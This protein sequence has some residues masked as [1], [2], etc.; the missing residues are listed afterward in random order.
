MSN[1]IQSVVQRYIETWN[2]TNATRRRALLREVYAEDCAYTDPL[3]D[4]KGLDAIDGF[5]GAVQKQYPG[6]VFSLGGAID[7]HHEQAR[8][9]WHAGPP[10]AADPLA[11]G[12]DVAIF[13]N[14]RIR[15][16]YGFMDKAP[17]G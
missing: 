7:A 4:A 9:T 14:G 10:G 15:R 11:I 12:F 2:E 13:E 6:L 17:G 16:I 8:F 5:V 1:E 3:V